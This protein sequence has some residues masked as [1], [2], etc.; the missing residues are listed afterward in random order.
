MAPHCRDKR[1]PRMFPDKGFVSSH[2]QFFE[3]NVLHAFGG[4]GEGF[5]P[6]CTTGKVKIDPKVTKEVTAEDPA[7]CEARGFINRFHIEHG[8]ADLLEYCDTERH[9][10]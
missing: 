4:S 7:L 8:R 2:S 10:G 3:F 9:L 6:K 5:K 1:Q